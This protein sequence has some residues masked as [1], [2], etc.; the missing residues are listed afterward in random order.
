MGLFSPAQVVGYIALALG[1]TAF[2]QRRD[3]R[4]KLFNATQ[5]LVYA[6]HF[7]LLGNLPASSSSL[8]SS[9]RSFL[10]LRYRSWL[11]GALIIGASVS[12]G[13]AFARST[14]GWLPVIGSCIATMAIFTMR[15]VPFRCVLLASTDRKSVV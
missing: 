4:L 8:L 13:A 2:L 11:L 3:D 1:I 5:G 10:A 9:F 14:A 15:G 12:L 7:L 6:L